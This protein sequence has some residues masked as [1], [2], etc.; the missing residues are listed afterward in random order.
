MTS[1]RAVWRELDRV[2]DAEHAGLKVNVCAIDSG[3][4]TQHVYDYCRRRRDK[5]IAIKGRTQD[6][7]VTIKR[8]ESLRTKKPMGIHLHN[9][10]VNVCKDW[11][12]GRIE[13]GI[14]GDPPF[15]IPM[16]IAEE[17]CRS[18]V[19]EY[20]ARQGNVI[21][22]IQASTENHEWDC[23][24][25]NYFLA[26]FKKRSVMRKPRAVKPEAKPAEPAAPAPMVRRSRGKGRKRGHFTTSY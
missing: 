22:W 12:H 17:Y 14:E 15:M 21:K 3:Y 26:R 8:P 13:A 19:S 10:N 4:N 25:Y 11:V 1:E 24:I 2:L 7:F 20:P 5:C 6:A 16:D 18:M 23:E 9:I